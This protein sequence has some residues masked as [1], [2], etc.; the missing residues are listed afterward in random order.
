MLFSDQKERYQKNVAT[1][2]C[3]MRSKS[4]LLNVVIKHKLNSG[5]PL[6]LNPYAEFESCTF[7]FFSFVFLYSVF[8]IQYIIV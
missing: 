8:T 6:M 5:K 3:S 4:M 1:T 7:Y 2:P